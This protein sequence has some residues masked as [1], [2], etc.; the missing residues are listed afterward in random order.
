[1][2][3]VMLHTLKGLFGIRTE[4]FVV[5]GDEADFL[6]L[7]LRAPGDT[8]DEVEEDF[9]AFLKSFRILSPRKQR[10]RKRSRK[11]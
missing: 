6:V 10:K 9:L 11:N 4:R 5:L 1:M 2:P 3:E 8:F 7:K